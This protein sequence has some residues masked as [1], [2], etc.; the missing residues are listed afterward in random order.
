MTTTNAIQYRIHNDKHDDDDGERWQR[1][2]VI[3]Q[4]AGLV[5]LAFGGYMPARK[6]A[7]QYMAEHQHMLPWRTSGQYHMYV[8]KRLHRVIHAYLSHGIVKAVHTG[9]IGVVWCGTDYAIDTIYGKYHINNDYD[10]CIQHQGKSSLVTIGKETIKGVVAGSLLGLA[11]KGHRLYYAKLG[12]RM[13]G[14]C[15]V[16]VGVLRVIVDRYMSTL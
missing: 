14:G 2:G 12:V 13:G 8:K 5:G 16:M 4:A 7:Y 9:M 15:G 11:G 3:V 10:D 6:A 1:Y